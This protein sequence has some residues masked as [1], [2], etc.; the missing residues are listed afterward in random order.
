MDKR[1]DHTKTEKRL[2]TMWEKGGYLTPKIDKK[3][4]PFTILLPPPN[5]NDPLHAVHS[6]FGVEDI[7]CRYQRMKGTPTLFLPG[8]DHAGIETQYVFEKHLEK[9]G[10]SRFDYDRKTLYEM[11]N[12]FVEENRGIAKEQLSAVGYGL[13]RPIASNENREG[14][15]Q[16]RRVQLKLIY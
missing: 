8:T 1:Y 4:K 6:L 7:L 13:T 10:K 14:R 15:A 2:Y 11:I 5:A 9:K 16:N 3:K 12:D